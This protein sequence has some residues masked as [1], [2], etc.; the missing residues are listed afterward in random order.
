MGLKKIYTF[1]SEVRQEFK[2]ITFPSR[3]EFWSNFSVVV[4]VIIIASLSFMLFDY[5]IHNI[6]TFLLNIGK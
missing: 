4:I 6:I 5:F 3:Q 2:S 1:Y